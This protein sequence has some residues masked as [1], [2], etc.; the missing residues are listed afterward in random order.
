MVR[1]MEDAEMLRMSKGWALV[2]LSL[3]SWA[4][5]GFVVYLAYVILRAWG[6]L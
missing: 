4:V 5:V 6:A 1:Q 2:G 3:A